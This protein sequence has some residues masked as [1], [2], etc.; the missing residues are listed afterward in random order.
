MREFAELLERRSQLGI[1]LGQEL[2]G[3]VCPRAELLAE[4][5]QGKTKTE[6]PLLGAVVEI[7]LEPAPLLVARRDDPRARGT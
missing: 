3:A 5:L 4:K 1:R 6:Q 7:A 2:A